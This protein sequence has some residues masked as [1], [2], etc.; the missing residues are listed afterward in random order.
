MRTRLLIPFVLLALLVSCDRSSQDWAKAEQ[1][2]TVQAYREFIA[3]HP[4]SPLSGQA[5]ERIEEI[6]FESAK[7]V[8]SPD[9]Y[10]EFLQQFP[11]GGFADKARERIDE[12]NLDE[13]IALN[14]IAALEAYLL[15][16]P[17]GNLTDRAKRAISKLKRG[18]FSA[19]LVDDEGARQEVER[20]Q[21]FYTATGSWIGQRPER[22]TVAFHLLFEFQ[23]GRVRTE[24]RLEIPFHEIRFMEFEGKHY[25][26]KTVRIERHDGS[27]VVVDHSHHPDRVTM[28]DA[29][30]GVARQID[31]EQ[32]RYAADEEQ[33]QHLVLRGFKGR[34]VAESGKTGDYF[35][36]DGAVARIELRYP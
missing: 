28:Y 26:E 35:I 17:E 12:I 4:E 5:R 34:A 36:E 8:D 22:S 19:T 14:S 6:H 16:H 32:I 33:G 23:E 13:V 10:T 20:L 24:E 1:E 18:P 30:G 31:P 7:S 9:A 27:R 15:Q 21:A 3:T 25:S 29:D 11:D 2:N